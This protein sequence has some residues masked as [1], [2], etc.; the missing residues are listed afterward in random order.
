MYATPPLPDCELTRMTASYVRA[1]SAGSRGRYGIY[2]GGGKAQH[3]HRGRS[4]GACETHLERSVGVLLAIAESLL[5]R[6]LETETEIVTGDSQPTFVA[7]ARERG[8]THLVRSRERSEDEFTGVRSTRVD[9]NV[10]ASRDDFDALF[11]VRKVQL[12]AHS[13]RVH[14]QRERDQV[15]VSGTFAVTEQATL[16]SVGTGH[17]SQLG[18]GDTRAAVVVGVERD[19]DVFSVLDV[20]AEVL[21]LICRRSVPFGDRRARDGERER[22]IKLTWSA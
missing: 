16:D 4:T 11:E 10:G 15:D 12:G 2:T 8:G 6:V 20:A 13:L 18:R 14:V 5:D 1:Q 3:F 17:E 22:E 21:D 19:D 7:E 9:G